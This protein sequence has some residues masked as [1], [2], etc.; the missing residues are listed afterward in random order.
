M[1]SN[2]RKIGVGDVVITERAKANVL[3]AL[4]RNRL[5][6]GYWT[7][8]FERRFGDLHSREF[9][10]FFNSGTDAL[11]IGL[12]AMKEKYG[13]KDGS[14]VLVP[15]LTFVASVNVI[16]QNNLKPIFVDV[17]RYY[18]MDANDV[19]AILGRYEAADYE[20]PVAAMPVHLFGQTA[21]PR[22]YSLAHR[23]GIRIIADSCETMFVEG[24]AE[25]DVSCFSTF[26]CHVIQTGVGGF[27]TTNDSQLA[28][29]ILSYG[30]H[31]RSGIYV[32]IDEELGRNEII[33]AR[34]HFDRMGYSS[35]ATEME[36]AIGCAELDDWERNIARRREIAARLSSSF[37]DLPLVLPQLRIGAESAWMM[38]PLLAGS[39][40]ERDALVQHL[41]S[42]GVETRY[43]LPL[44]NQPYFK[45][46]FGDIE[47]N[48]PH[49][50]RINRTGFYI[51]CHPY[52]S[53]L[54]VDYMIETLRA[55]YRRT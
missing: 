31:G 18:G 19:A 23:F 8:Q 6:R 51:G 39:G 52:L 37:D 24:C 30:N 45:K 44:T 42:N 7:K 2:K 55:F 14:A 9:V 38:Y 50:A 46:R 32:S 20:M 34:F 25:G 5:S 35:R 4:N 3:D 36:A 12:A 16:L 21:D 11:R 43:M 40:D 49:A 10:Y 48:Y 1:I 17:D 15:A 28:D 22:I 41:E 53:D 29:L 54:D 33:E 26:A 13:W 47:A 27:A